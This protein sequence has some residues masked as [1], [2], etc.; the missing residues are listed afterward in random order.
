MKHLL[1]LGSGYAHLHLLKNLASEPMAAAQITLVTPHP[2]QLY[3][4]AISRFVAGNG[5]LD[6]AS[7]DLTALLHG[8]GVRWQSGSAVALDAN[9]RSVTLDDGSSVGYDV[10]SVNCGAVQDRQK[11]EQS[12]PGARKHA[13]F[14]RPF[15]GFATLW[16][17]V[18]ELG[19]QRPLRVAVIGA[20]LAGIELAMTIAQRL[21]GAAL[22]LICG[23]TLPGHL[24]PEKLQTRILQTL[25]R[26]RITVLQESA[27]RIEAEQVTLSNGARLLCDVPIM[28]T[29]VQAPPWLQH[30]GLALDEQGF[31]T[32]DAMQR[33]ASHP[34]VFAAGD[35]SSRDDGVWQR[36]GFHAR[37]AAAVLT[38]NV[39]AVMAGIAP[40]A[41]LTQKQKLILL[42]SGS[43]C[44]IAGWG[45]WS[46]QGRWVWW[47]K[48]RL[49]QRALKALRA[50]P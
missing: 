4:A 23:S 3:F 2:R 24:F 48:N 13:L 39:R 44:A 42:N 32:V 43:K 40:E 28:A 19:Q 25:K 29:G 14:V 46:A 30:S 18:L 9:S 35:V 5:T 27:V 49:D 8:S 34:Q 20:G 15:E 41:A 17:Q 26:L 47:L 33:S 12:I 6:E 31:L 50:N 16:P 7:I 22:T 11:I 10:L 21:P 37:Q 38:R 36:N 45:D 1:L